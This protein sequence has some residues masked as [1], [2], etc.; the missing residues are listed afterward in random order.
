[1]IQ[2]PTPISQLQD[3]GNFSYGSRPILTFRLPIEPHRLVP[4]KSVSLDSIPPSWKTRD[5]TEAVLT[6]S[7]GKVDNR[8]SYGNNTIQLRYQTCC[9]VVVLSLGGS[10]P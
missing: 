7:A 10:L 9:V 6:K 5:Q 3:V 8:S 1:M 4:R 2:S